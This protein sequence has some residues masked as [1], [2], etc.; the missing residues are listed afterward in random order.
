MIQT[1]MRFKD[2]QQISLRPKIL[3]KDIYR[4]VGI[5][6]N[7]TEPWTLLRLDSWFLQSLQ[8]GTTYKAD[9]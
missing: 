5:I 1:P 2:S 7:S 8:L 9:A 3:F 6:M 4:P